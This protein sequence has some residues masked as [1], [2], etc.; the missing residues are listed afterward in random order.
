MKKRMRGACEAKKRWELKEKNEG[1]LGLGF[2]FEEN[3]DLS[4]QGQETKINETHDHGFVTPVHG[5]YWPPN[6]F[7]KY[8][9]TAMG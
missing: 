2:S 3:M 8:K 1:I 6:V 7:E 9:P 4:A 5:P